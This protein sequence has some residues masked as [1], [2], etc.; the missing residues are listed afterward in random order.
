MIRNYQR[1]EGASVDLGPIYNSINVL[2]NEV[3]SLITITK[4]STLTSIST[5]FSAI[6]ELSSSITDLSTAFTSHTS[7]YDW[8]LGTLASGVQSSIDSLSSSIMDIN[9][10]ISTLSTAGGGGKTLT[11]PTESEHM[12]TDPVLY[13]GPVTGEGS[14]SLNPFLNTYMKGVTWSDSPSTE[15]TN[16]RQFPAILEGCV[17]YGDL[18]CIDVYNCH[19]LSITGSRLVF[20]NC[21][22]IALEGGLCGIVDINKANW[23]TA[24]GCTYDDVRLS[25]CDAGLFGA[26]ELNHIHIPDC[27]NITL[28]SCNIKDIS[29]EYPSTVT[30]NIDYYVNDLSYNTINNINVTAMTVRMRNNNIW[31]A[32]F[33]VDYNLL[34][35]TVAGIIPLIFI[36]NTING[37]SI[38][39]LNHEGINTTLPAISM[40]GLNFM[41]NTIS[42]LRMDLY[43]PL[44]LWSNSIDTYEH[45]IGAFISARDN[46]VLEWDCEVS[47]YSALLHSTTVD[48]TLAM[49]YLNTV[50]KWNVYHGITDESLFTDS[51][52]PNVMAGLNKLALNF[53]RNSVDYAT[54]DVLNP[55][56][57]SF[58]KGVSSARIN[59]CNQLS[60]QGRDTFMTL[61]I[62]NAIQFTFNRS[63]LITLDVG[64]VDSL[65]LSNVYPIFS[66]AYIYSMNMF[67]NSFIP[68]GY[69]VSNL[70]VVSADFDIYPVY[71]GKFEVSYDYITSFNYRQ[72]DELTL[73][74]FNNRINNASINGGFITVSGNTFTNIFMNVGTANLYYNQLYK[75][76][77][78]ANN[79]SATSCKI[80]VG[81]FYYS[82][83][84]GSAMTITKLSS[85]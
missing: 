51:L 77:G 33:Y 17:I 47:P 82:S 7:L 20:N 42:Q 57:V 41:T 69:G 30:S 84:S 62:A 53:S 2:Q 48:E 29:I 11:N 59:V 38:Y 23:A 16:G 85:L 39:N 83:S 80:T 28:R 60:V 70:Y 26:C 52:S 1:S 19:F 49:L 35:S 4:I 56:Y 63:Q 10:I 67:V 27:K 78:M 76:N 54:F 72:M 64:S 66:K 65:G 14:P 71:G 45:T 61:D 43:C 55:L 32:N 12:F 6:N 81:G 50:R 34:Q 79:F 68:D 13:S 9:G 18:S 5:G 15:V 21:G 75:L 36:E 74:M 8:K 25:S 31:T 37:L 44:T 73:D 46:T 24:G 22:S 40:N 3:N 58:T